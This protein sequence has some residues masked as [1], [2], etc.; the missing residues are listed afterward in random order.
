M[1]STWS[2]SSPVY[3]RQEENCYAPDCAQR[4]KEKV[5]LRLHST[6]ERTTRMSVECR[7]RDFQVPWH[8]TSCANVF[9]QDA[10][11]SFNSCSELCILLFSWKPAHNSLIY[12]FLLRF[13]SP[14]PFIPRS[15]SGKNFELSS[16]RPGSNYSNGRTSTPMLSMILTHSTHTHARFCALTRDRSL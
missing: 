7:A 5:V 6:P 10:K 3:F 15:F 2:V 9:L 1:S 13:K 14:I 11:E 8:T 4:E 12:W 16:D